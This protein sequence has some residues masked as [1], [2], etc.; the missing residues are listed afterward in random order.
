MKIKTM[1]TIAVI[2]SLIFMSSPAISQTTP[3]ITVY[4]ADKEKNT[5]KAV[6]ICPGGGYSHLATKHEGSD[7][8]EWLSGNGITAVVLKYR[9]PNHHYTWPLEDAQQAMRTIREN[10]VNWD[11]NPHE[12]GVMGFSA[13]GHLASTLLTHYDSVSRPDFGILFYP[14]ITFDPAYTHTGSVNN[15]L[16]DAKTE[17]LITYFSNE[18]QVTNDT[19]STLLLHSDDDAAVPIDN[20]LL[21]YDALQKNHVHA[22]FYKFPTGGHGWGYRDS[23]PFHELMKSIV[24]EWIGKN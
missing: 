22:S 4:P 2:L 10:A 16:G 13:G 20:S 6:L 24:L 7:F 17:A 11:V 18:Q 9:M 3:D 21:F 8:A 23:F 14:V 15:L 19:P 12:V 5:G 1:K